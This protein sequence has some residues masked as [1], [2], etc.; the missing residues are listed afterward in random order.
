M[1]QAK[2]LTID[3]EEIIR[4]SFCDY[5]SDAGYT[6]LEADNGEKGLELFQQERPDLVLL[7]LSM[8]GMGGLKVLEHLSAHAP[9]TP[10]IIISGTGSMDDAIAALRLGAWD[11]VT[12]P[13]QDYAQLRRFI[14]NHLERAR[15]EQ[16]NEYYR[17]HLED[18]VAR[19][20]A[21]AREARNMVEALINVPPDSALLI[22]PDG[23]LLTCNDIAAWRLR[24]DP[25]HVQ[26]VNMYDHFPSEVADD[27]RRM[28]AR[29]VKTKAPVRFQDQREGI[30]FDSHVHPILD[31]NGAVTQLAV[32]ARDITEFKETEAALEKANAE[33]RSAYDHVEEQVQQRTHE[34]GKRI[35]ELNCL[36]VLARLVEDPDKSVDDVLS[37]LPEIIARSWRYPEVASCRIEH[38]GKVYSSSGFQPSAWVQRADILASKTAVG[39]VEVH[40]S[41]QRP[42]AWEGPFLQEERN[43][44]NEIADRLGQFLE[45]RLALKNLERSERRLRNEKQKFFNLLEAIPAFVYVKNEDRRIDYANKVVREIYGNVQGRS[46]HEV[47]QG[48]QSPCD[49]CRALEIFETGEPLKW[50]WTDKSGNVRK[51]TSY[52]FVD[53]DGASMVI[54]L[55]VDITDN[56]RLEDELRKA[57]SDAEA[58][59][60]AKSEF[61]A[62][63]SHEIRTPMNAVIGMTDLALQTSL[64]GEQR[65][66]METIQESAN[67]LLAI[68]NDIL[69]LS[70]IEAKRI[71]LE[72]V[73]F[74]LQRAM[75]STLRTL[76][77]QA[78][79]KGLDLDF[80]IAP[81]TPQ[82]VKGDLARLRQVLINLIG[83]AIKFTSQGGVSVSIK[84]AN[85]EPNDPGDDSLQLLFK[86][87]DTGVGI[88]RDSREAIFESFRQAD[89]STTRQYGGTGLGLSICKQLV[90]LMGGRIWVE[91]I[92]RPGS[93]FRFLVTL[94]KG[95]PAKALRSPVRPETRKTTSA[96]PLKVLLAE[97][98]PLNVKVATRSLEKMGHGVSAAQDGEKCLDILAS[99]DFDLVLMDVEMPGMN[100]LEAARRI[101][102]GEAGASSRDIPI[103]AMTAHAHE[104]YKKHCL[105]AG[106]N[107]YVTKPVNFPELSAIIARIMAETDRP[108]QGNIREAERDAVLNLEA[109][110]ERFEDDVELLMETVVIVLSEL[111]GRLR[112]LS[113]ALAAGDADKAR[114]NAHS[115]KGNLGA[116]GAEKASRAAA[117]IENLLLAGKTEEASQHQF[118]LDS[119]A[120]EMLDALPGQMVRQVGVLPSEADRRQSP[121]VPGHGATAR[122][123]DRSDQTM[124][125]LDSSASGLRLNVGSEN[126]QVGEMLS[127]A[128]HEPD[129]VVSSVSAEVVWRNG[130]ELGCRIVRKAA[131]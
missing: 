75:A 76:R 129:G 3:D 60:R 48:R 62:R 31:K 6:M 102:L 69:D 111:P 47:F 50:E 55:G 115:L 35:K 104:E 22:E 77:V 66:Y 97:D 1:T 43:L 100:G 63:M 106:M 33:L 36:Y 90:E 40:Y 15:L 38:G 81:D 10:V 93:E 84:R 112:Q 72:Q 88:P 127:L 9:Q 61:L 116:I 27:R 123:Q 122:L 65:D 125:I 52:S 109:V 25:N 74:D 130:E 23:T 12:K 32:Y 98:T 108:R 96:Q 16:E 4:E 107:D 114:Q 49:L 126:F 67:H 30:V 78:I 70:K 20:T 7:D 8:P 95:D 120:S 110:L 59:S 99:E 101:R 34:L 117:K 92:D 29:A 18:E 13:V 45:H 118:E 41:E 28:M 51:M 91:D 57:K 5:L 26:G 79:N 113:K 58:A 87:A 46:C 11:Y 124:Q 14:E 89:S 54:Q 86:V 131:S 24:L 82:V 94:G 53:E 68:I 85:G 17:Q 73:D 2:I 44:I 128:M 39:A 121:R 19:R 42:D 64:K 56:K 71:E 105:E 103:I 37:G 119:V 83:N 80:D 21:E